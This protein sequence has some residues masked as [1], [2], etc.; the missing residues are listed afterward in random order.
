[1]TGLLAVFLSLQHASAQ[2]S[3]F[4]YQGQLRSTSQ[5]FVGLVDFEFRLYDQLVDGNQI[6]L[7]QNV[8]DVPVEDGLFQV[9]LDFGADVFNGDNR[10][11]EITVNGS[12]LTPRQ[13]ITATPYALIATGLATGSVDADAVDAAQIQLRVTGICPGGSSINAIGE[14]GTVT[15][16]PDIDTDEQLLPLDGANL[17]ISNGNMV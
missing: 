3:T 10:F 11:L 9:E 16:Q 8:S 5:N 7:V 2:Q 15:C 13:K 14:D 4:T 6:G 1:M 12:T 17:I